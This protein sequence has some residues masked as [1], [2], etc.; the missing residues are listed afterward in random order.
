MAVYSTTL[1]LVI[2]S[3]SGMCADVSGTNDNICLV[4]TLHAVSDSHYYGFHDTVH[5]HGY[6]ASVKPKGSICLLVK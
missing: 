3:V 1:V 5:L 4:L 6:T 2:V